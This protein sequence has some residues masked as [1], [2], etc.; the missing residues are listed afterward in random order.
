M[1]S[2]QCIKIAHSKCVPQTEV[3]KFQVAQQE[4]KLKQEQEA[5][6]KELLN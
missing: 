2:K 5:E 3:E 4:A 1:S 6:V